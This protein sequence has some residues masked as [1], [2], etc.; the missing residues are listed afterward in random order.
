NQ[1]LAAWL[2][3]IEQ[4]APGLFSA[5]ATGSGQL[6]VLNQ[7][8]SVNDSAHPAKAGSTIQMFGT[9]QGFVSGGPPDGVP[10][11]EA[12]KTAVLPR[13]LINATEATVTYSGLAPGYVGVWQI[14]AVVPTSVPPGVVSV[15]VTMNDVISTL[16]TNTGNRITTSIRVSQ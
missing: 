7:D 9:G 3:R 1:I 14:N 12:I 4:Y 8:N 16:D 13:V 11:T 10:A 2:F 15:V 5:D 6:A